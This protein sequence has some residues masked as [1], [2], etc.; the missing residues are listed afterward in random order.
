MTNIENESLNDR[1]K[2]KIGLYTVVL[3][4]NNER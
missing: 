1:T 2:A 4:L 3:A